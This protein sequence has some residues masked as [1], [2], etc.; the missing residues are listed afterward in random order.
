MKCPSCETT[1]L[2]HDTRDMA[3]TYRG[4][5]TFIHAVTGDYCM[6]CGEVVLDAGESTRTSTDMLEFNK[7]INVASL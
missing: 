4:E 5:S 2:T 7:Q 3:Y 1:K 6:A